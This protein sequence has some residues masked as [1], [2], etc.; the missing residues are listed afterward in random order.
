MWWR[1]GALRLVKAGLLGIGLLSRISAGQVPNAATSSTRDL[2]LREVSRASARERGVERAALQKLYDVAAFAPLWIRHG[3]P[4]RQAIQVI[5]F[6]EAVETKGLEAAD[7]DVDALRRATAGSF[8]SD[9]AVVRFDVSLSRAVVHMIADLHLGR[10]IPSAVGFDLPS[11][12]DDVDLAALVLAVSRADDVPAAISGAEP[13][14]AGYA[15]L[16]R[17]LGRYRALAA[18]TSLRL[19]TSDQRTVRPGDRYANA[20]ILRRLL[21]A[22]GDLD[23]GVAASPSRVRTDSSGAPIYDAVLAQAVG[24][25][26]R[27]HGLEADGVIGPATMSQLRTPLAYRR[28]QIELALE[29]WRW[30]PDRAPERYA[31]VNVPAFRLY[32]F[33]HDATASQPTL[34]MDVIV[35]QAEGRHGTPTFVGTMQE[36]VFR[37][38]WDVPTSIARK[39][40]IPLFRRR[41]AYFVNEGF[42]IVRRGDGDAAATR[43]PPTEANFSRVL[44]GSLR[45]RQRPGPANALGPVKFVFPNRYNVYLHGT[46]AQQLFANARRDFSHGCIRVEA[47]ADLAE[48][49][50]RDQAG[51][52]RTAIEAAMQ[53]SARTQHVRITRPMVVYVLYAT[54]VVDGAG[55]VH[56]YPDI[57][58]LD[59][60]LDRA[61]GAMERSPASRTQR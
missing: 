29:R 3:L 52:D 30:L 16:E 7:Y 14:Y 47:P 20:A 55:A 2:A 49:V 36:V 23:A 46:P 53:D 26:Q 6:L 17:A 45:L 22:L 54:V 5:R 10:T 38:Y 21:V 61:L 40:L 12:H 59:R 58:G 13:P 4:S 50:L 39:E 42:E 48:L 41:P 43:H 56:F 34:A 18:D 28:R 31:V 51:W 27:R 33:E 60:A 44:S 9:S 8:D 24:R 1:R 15:A 32:A 57:Y 25:F 37:P 35:G 11:A 19:P